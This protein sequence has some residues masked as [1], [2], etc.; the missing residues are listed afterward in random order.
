MNHKK[1]YSNSLINYIILKTKLNNNLSQILYYF[2]KSD[3][4]K[5]FNQYS[6]SLV[7]NLEFYTLTFLY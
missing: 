1:I 6:K 2:I 5:I 7:F 4:N 3:N